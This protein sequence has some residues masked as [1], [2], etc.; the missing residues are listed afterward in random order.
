KS[1]EQLAYFKHLLAIDKKRK[2]L[3]SRKDDE[4][5]Y[6]EIPRMLIGYKIKLVP[7]DSLKN[8]DDGLTEAIAAATSWFRFSNKPFRL[9]NLK[10]YRC[11]FRNNLFYWD[12]NEK[13]EF[14]KE[15][16][17]NKVFKK[18]HL[19]L[20]DICEKDFI[21]TSQ[22]ELEQKLE[23]GFQSL[24]KEKQEDEPINTWK[25][26]NLDHYDASTQV[27]IL[28]IRL[29]LQERLLKLSK[30]GL[31]DSDLFCKPIQEKINRLPKY[32]DERK[33]I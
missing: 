12:C 5:N 18:G 10:S 23:E 2:E 13:D 25:D 29:K 22:E 1:K 17:Q 26:K 14:E 32:E 4:D 6:I 30:I 3:S 31:K 28:K 9:C 8:R 27:E 7:V 11:E 15:Y 24:E 21:V 19:K 20:L 33:F 16:F